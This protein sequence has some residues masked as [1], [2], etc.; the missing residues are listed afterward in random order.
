MQ[1]IN[2]LQNNRSVFRMV[3]AFIVPKNWTHT[4]SVSGSYGRPVDES[5]VIWEHYLKSYNST[6]NVFFGYLNRFLNYFTLYVPIV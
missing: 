3:V 4:P 5:F 6:S 2:L 1:W